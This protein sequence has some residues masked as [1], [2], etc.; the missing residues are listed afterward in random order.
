MNPKGFITKRIKNHFGSFGSIA[1]TALGVYGNVIMPLQTYSE[2]RKEGSSVGVSAAKAIGES[3]F[4]MSTPG[5][6]YG[7]LQIA[8]AVGKTVITAGVEN[9]KH[10]STMYKGNFGGNFNLSKNGYTMRQRGLSAINRAGIN[11]AQVLGNEA[12]D[13]H[14]QQK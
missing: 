14:M 5:Q 12:R 3:V 11:N 7:V 9:A 6:I 8:D 2:S 4:Y 1:G 10:S 13:F